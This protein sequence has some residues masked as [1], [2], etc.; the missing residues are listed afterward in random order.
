M[1]RKNLPDAKKPLIHMTPEELQATFDE[2]GLGTTFGLLK[3]ARWN[4]HAT[5]EI[6]QVVLMPYA[7]VVVSEFEYGDGEGHRYADEFVAEVERTPGL[8]LAGES[9]KKRVTLLDT[10]TGVG[11]IGTLIDLPKP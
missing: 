4:E 5:L 10:R 9:L 7:Y 6:V 8:L 11:V 2:I 1:K 3:E